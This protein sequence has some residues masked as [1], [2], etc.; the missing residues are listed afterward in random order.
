MKPRIVIDFVLGGRAWCE[1][2]T[3]V[4]VT[5]ENID[6]L[7]E[8]EG[9]PDMRVGMWLRE[10]EHKAYTQAE[11]EDLVASEKYDIV[12]SGYFLHI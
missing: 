6:Q 4:T 5:P 11:M 8:R 9:N 1:V 3:F 7:R 2:E 12:T 10:R